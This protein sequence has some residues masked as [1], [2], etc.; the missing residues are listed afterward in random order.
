MSI[1]LLF[2][3][4]SHLLLLF[5]LPKPK[6]PWSPKYS[7]QN[8][9]AQIPFQ[10]QLILFTHSDSSLLTPVLIS[11][12]IG[13]GCSLSR[14]HSPSLMQ[15]SPKLLLDRLAIA[16]TSAFSCYHRFCSDLWFY[17]LVF[18]D[19]E[20]L[21]AIGRIRERKGKKRVKKRKEERDIKNN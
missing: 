15:T 1:P 4:P 5:I 14:P 17:G 16:L 7:I 3:T 19:D 21:N 18:H 9:F 6:P 11:Q 13:L 20:N 12:Q 10:S 2:E 8:Q